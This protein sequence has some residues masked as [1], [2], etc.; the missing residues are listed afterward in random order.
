MIFPAAAFIDEG[1][2]S[3]RA[4]LNAHLYNADAKPLGF[5]PVKK[6]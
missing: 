2:A 4:L 6:A 5:A 1:K 3:P